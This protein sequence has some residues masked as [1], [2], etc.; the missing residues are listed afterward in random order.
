MKITLELDFTL[1]FKLVILEL[2]KLKPTSRF[3]S[4]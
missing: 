2:S 1:G 3:F 4:K